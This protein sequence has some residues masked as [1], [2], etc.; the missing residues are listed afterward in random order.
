MPPQLFLLCC[1]ASKHCKDM[2]T[3]SAT[4]T[5]KGQITLPKALREMLG[6]RFG[7]RVVLSV[8]PKTKETAMRGKQTLTIDEVGGMLHRP[9]MKALSVEEM[10]EAIARGICEKY[11]RR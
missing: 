1:K 11:G 4:L 7:D 6:L 5:S 8:N 10:N 2:T 9:G 3:L